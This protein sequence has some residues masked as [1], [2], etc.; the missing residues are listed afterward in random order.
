MKAA[1][2]IAFITTTS[3]IRV[4]EIAAVLHSNGKSEH[5][6]LVVFKSGSEI[7]VSTGAA[8]TIAKKL[9]G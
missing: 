9:R 2:D 6:F 5:P 4:S 7:Y 8:E 3:F 1:D